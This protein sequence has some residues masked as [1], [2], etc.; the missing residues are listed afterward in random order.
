MRHVES[1]L[2]KTEHHVANAGNA[3]FQRRER[4]GHLIHRQTDIGVPAALNDVYPPLTAGIAASRGRK[5][6]RTAAQPAQQ[7]RGPHWRI[8]I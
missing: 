1:A 4:A 3:A 7:E 8:R 5:R 2:A 6:S